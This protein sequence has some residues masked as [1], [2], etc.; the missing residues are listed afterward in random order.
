VTASTTAVEGDPATPPDRPLPGLLQLPRG[1]VRSVRLLRLKALL[2]KRFSYGADVAVGAG[3]VVLSP[4][5]FELG[6][7]VRI[8]RGLHVEADVVVGDDVLFSSQV[9]IVSDDHRF[10]D[11][12]RTVF[13][14]GRKPAALVTL[15]GDNL[16]GF[17]TVVVGPVT[18]GRGVIVG[19]GSLVTRDLPPYTVCMG[20]PARPVRLR[21]SASE[22]S[23]P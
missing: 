5:R 22:E 16:I 19:A 8:G 2:G 23:A 4:N 1:V 9:A 17:G 20:R 10:D 13:D 11:P 18:I 14:Q 3:C 6:D 21:F 15:E 7:R 12:A